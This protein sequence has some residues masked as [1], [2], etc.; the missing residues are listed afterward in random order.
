VNRRSFLWSAAAVTAAAGAGGAVLLLTDRAT[1]AA[2]ASA[3]PATGTARVVRTDLVTTEP[4]FGTLG[5]AGEVRVSGSTDGHSY[6]WLPAPGAV[7]AA[8]QPLYEVDGRGVPLLPGDRPVW[9]PFAPGMTPGPDVTQLNNGMVAL[10]FAHGLTGSPRFGTAS[11]TAVRRWQ[12]ALGVPVTGR[13]E[14]GEVVFA[15]AP[16]RVTS[17]SADVGARPEPGVPLVVATSTD[18]VVTLPVPVDQAFLLHVSDPVTVTLPDART[19]TPGTVSSVS[20]VAVAPAQD[21]PSDRPPVSTVDVSVTL[22]DPGA[23]AAYTTAPVS[24]SVTTASVRGVLA[25]PVTALVARAGAGFAVTVVDGSRRRQVPVTAG[26][27]ADTLVQ[28][29]GGGLAAG[30]VV[31]VPAS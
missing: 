20:P 19:T 17:V 9:R 3:A 10:G 16:L 2:T 26:V 27:F 13:V 22:A 28:V 1:P 12:H 18:R 4:L 24:V 8:G 7:V 14:L 5:F 30:D 11:A 25:V 23:A 6:T 21:A 31:E 15:H 29:S